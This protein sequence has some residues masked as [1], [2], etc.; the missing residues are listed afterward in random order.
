[1][2]FRV[3]STYYK[4]LF[5]SGSELENDHDVASLILLRMP[6]LKKNRDPLY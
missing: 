3:V 4:I 5:Y 2:I 1:L 6:L